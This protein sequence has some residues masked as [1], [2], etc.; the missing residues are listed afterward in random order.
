[1]EICDE[2]VSNGNSSNSIF[3]VKKMAISYNLKSIYDQYLIYRMPKV[4]LLKYR[5]KTLVHSVKNCQLSWH[6]KFSDMAVWYFLGSLVHWREHSRRNFEGIESSILKLKDTILISLYA[7]CE[8]LGGQ[9]NV[10]PRFHQQHGMF[11]RLMLQ[12]FVLLLP[13]FFSFLVGFAFGGYS[14]HLFGLFPNILTI[15]DFRS[16]IYNIRNF[17]SYLCCCLVCSSFTSL[18][19][20]PDESC[21]DGDFSH[22]FS[23]QSLLCAIARSKVQIS[24]L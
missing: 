18:W 3:E 6:E 20:F 13:F 19:S 14:L 16:S 23:S 4:N 1:M 9:D 10:I 12:F 22:L 7:W 11:Q 2:T 24:L 8:L 21:I 15:F 5:W 17:K